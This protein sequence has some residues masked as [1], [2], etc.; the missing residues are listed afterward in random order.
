MAPK[1]IVNTTMGARLSAAL[2]LWL[3]NVVFGSIVSAGY[4]QRAPEDLSPRG[5]LFLVL[6]MI[7]S[8]SLLSLAPGALGILIALKRRSVQ[9][10][11]LRHGLVWTTALGL[12]YAD[13]RIFGVFRFHLNEA[14][15]NS[16]T[17]PGAGDAL[18]FHAADFVLPV[19]AAIGI[20][21]TQAYLYRRFHST[22]FH[23]QGWGAR[24]RPALLGIGLLLPIVVAERN[25][26]AN[27]QIEGATE[28]AT[29]SELMPYYTLPNRVWRSIQHAPPTEGEQVF[30]L[31]NRALH[32]PKASLNVDPN[33]ARPNILILV[34]DGLRADMLGPTTMP[35]TWE[36]AQDS[37]VFQSHW[38]GG[39]CTRHGIFSLMYGLHGN[40]WGPVLA[41]QQSP[42]LIDTLLDLNYEPRIICSAAQSFPEF[43]STV[44]F[45][46]QDAIEDEFEG[47]AWQKDRQVA[48]RFDEWLDQRSDPER[49]FF[50]FSLLDSTHANYS[51]PKQ[52]T[53]FKPSSE[54][55]G[56]IQL[57]YG[58]EP[59]ERWALFNRYRNSV[60][61]ADWVVEQM[62][63]SLRQ[64]GILDNTIVLI[65]G[66]HGEEF[67]ENGFWGHHSNFSP[68]QVHVPFILR[69]PGI[70][71]GV[72]NGQTSHI[73]LP[74]TLLELLGTSPGQAPN[75]SLGQNLL[76]LSDDRQ[77]VSSSWSSLALKVAGEEVIVLSAYADHIPLRAFG[78]HWQP[79]ADEREVLRRET[80]S[81]V[82]L[83]SQ[84]QEFLR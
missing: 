12:L 81:L 56:Y 75:Y 33:G 24:L 62:L 31:E 4:L 14:I 79:L 40:Y 48:T 15:W 19:F 27:A 41:E 63:D 83:V 70:P 69:G 7:S 54:K 58:L 76:D 77:M 57:S 72:E 67:F 60:R 84:C 66:D 55:V 38:S 51:F 35:H 5:I 21:S 32:Y 26:Y 74:R 78:H 10:Q 25:L 1:A 30:E 43:R 8:V 64:R 16:I 29:L 71:V 11:A 52:E 61:H 65:T 42:V 39:N 2:L 44:W 6:G 68:E 22:A 28:I 80:P 3:L 53:F 73:D 18:H 34:L 37:R 45:H 23:H 17:T 49:P 20:I 50:A 36:F 59:D 9:A 46:V 13:T 82:N 47:E